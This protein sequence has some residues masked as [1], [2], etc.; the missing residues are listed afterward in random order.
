MI[1]TTVLKIFLPA[2]CIKTIYNSQIDIEIVLVPV[3]A[4][5][6]LISTLFCAIVIYTALDKLISLEPSQ[7]G[8]LILS[9]TFG[10]VTY[11]GIPVLTSLYGDESA[12][13]A[14]FYDLLATTPVLW[15]IGVPIAAKF[16][17]GKR[18]EIRESIKAITSLPPVWG[19]FV[20]LFLNLSET[21]LP[22][23]VIRALD[24]LSSTVVP[25][26]IFSIGLAIDIFKVKHAYVVIPA[27]IIKLFI[28]PLISFTTAYMLGLRGTAFASCFIEGAMPT[29]VLSLLIAARFKLDT[30]LSAFVIVASTIIF[31]ITLPIVIE[32]AENLP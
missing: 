16:G 11:L 8:V 21:S 29:M 1:N 26:M 12:K 5:I 24:T 27:I 14:L 32:V 2:L 13:Y 7:K 6:T 19:I 9:S 28:S 22:T 17:E 30:S 3:T 10:N 31:F 25:L 4:W 20:G 15:L 23:S 18:M